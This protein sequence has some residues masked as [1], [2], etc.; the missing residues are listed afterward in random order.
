[1]PARFYQYTVID[2]ASRERFIYPF[3]EQS[4]YSTIQF[5]NMA[6]QHFVYQPKIIQ[7]DNGVE[8]THFKDAKSPSF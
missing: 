1:M 4:S 8:F 6:I 5:M 2:E 3:K 7:T